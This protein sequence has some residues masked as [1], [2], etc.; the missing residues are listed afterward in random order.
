MKHLYSHHF[1]LVAGR[2]GLLFDLVS[3][4]C[5]GLCSLLLARVSV[6][7]SWRWAAPED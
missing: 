1:K 3:I 4:Q 5:R 7:L 6:A 2:R